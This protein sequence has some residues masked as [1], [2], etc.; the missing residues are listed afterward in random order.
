MI[1]VNLRRVLE[2]YQVRNDEKVSYAQLA[3]RIGVSLETV[4]S[5]ASRPG[6]NGTLKLVDRICRELACQPGDFLSFVEDT[7]H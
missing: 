6:Y 3:D 2:L 1:L 7:N 5:L 4:Q